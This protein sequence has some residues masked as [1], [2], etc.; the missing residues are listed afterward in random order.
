MFKVCSQE[1][2]KEIVRK[3]QQSGFQVVFTNGVFDILHVGHLRYLQAS[4]ALGDK[5]VVALN[6]D[7]SVKIL[8]GD[9]RPVNK[10][11]DRMELLSGLTVVDLVISFEEETP[12]NIIS[13]L[14][15][16]I[17]TKGGDYTPETVV[18]ADIV[19]EHGGSVR[20]IKFED[21][22]S[23]SSSIQRLDIKD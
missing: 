20:I 2:A 16:D 22:Y 15:P 10:L 5:L 12:F 13:A 7:T 11:K 9:S 1:D 8:K 17:I 19:M 18:G 23:T 4:K 3:W 6:S 21:G 14:I